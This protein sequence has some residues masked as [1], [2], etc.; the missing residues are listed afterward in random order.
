MKRNLIYT[1]LM[2][3]LVASLWT[4]CTSPQKNKE[5]VKLQDSVDIGPSDSAFYGHLG[6]GTGMSCLELITED[7]DTLVFEKT[8]EKT[9]EYGRILGEIANY[10]DRYAIT[11]CNDNQSI[12]VALN[13]S[14]LMQ[15][16]WLA[17][18]DSL[19]GFLLNEDGRVRELPSD[20]TGPSSWHL[21]NCDLIV[22]RENAAATEASLSNDTIE[23][24]YMSSDSLALH[25]IH[26]NTIFSFHSSNKQ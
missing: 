16:A 11:T 8:N 26:S 18:R 20:S 5:Y 7:G 22:C 13:I 9:G 1:L 19:K 12:R 6:E 2:P 24:L 4:G 10:T 23:I 25:N 3:M 15:K 17:D 21:Y 14:Q